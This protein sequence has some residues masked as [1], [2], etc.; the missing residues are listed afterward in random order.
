MKNKYFIANL[1]RVT[2]IFL[3]TMLPYTSWCQAVIM[4]NGTAISVF[5]PLNRTNDYC[6]YEVIYLSSDINTPGTIGKVGFQRVDGTNVDSIENVEIYMQHTP[7]TQLSAANFSTAGYTLVYSGSFPNDAGSGWREVTLN[8][9]F[10]YD[11]INNLMVLVVKGYQAAT[12]N[13]PVT[14]R[15]YYTNISPSPARA[16]RYYGNNPITISTALTT[17]VFT[18]NARLDFGPVG[19]VEINPGANTVYP[20]PS[21]GTVIFSFSPPASAG[22]H[23]LFIRNVNGQLIYVNKINDG[24][25]ISLYPLPRGIYFYETRNGEN[26][27]VTTGKLVLED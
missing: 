4:G 16:R 7:M 14:P 23:T 3:I 10:I 8:N 9:P 1:R 20:N 27:R 17:T 2:I 5:S 11:G 13:T 18:S 22:E 15:W 21:K 19:I 24:E 6:V 12:A 26:K 25:E